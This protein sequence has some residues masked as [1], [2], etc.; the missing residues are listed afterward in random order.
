MSCNALKALCKS[1]SSFKGLVQKWNEA[2]P[3]TYQHSESQQHCR[4]ALQNEQPLPPLERTPLD[5]HDASS[6]GGSKHHTDNVGHRDCREWLR[7]PDTVTITCKA[8]PQLIMMPDKHL[9]LPK[10]TSGLL[11]EGEASLQGLSGMPVIKYQKSVTKVWCHA[12]QYSA[13]G[14]LHAKYESKSSRPRANRC[15]HNT[16]QDRLAMLTCVW[17]RTAAAS[18]RRLERRLQHAAHTA[19]T[20]IVEF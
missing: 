18:G 11:P 10:G 5:R 13:S 16:W 9:L 7:R 19:A 20:I 3:T 8:Y 14:S 1:A 15:S 4:N 12:N 2:C 17:G 6:Q